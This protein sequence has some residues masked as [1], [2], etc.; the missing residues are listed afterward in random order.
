MLLLLAKLLAVCFWGE[1]TVRESRSRT[2]SDELPVRLGLRELP[3]EEGFSGVEPPVEV[4]LRGFVRGE[5]VDSRMLARERE[6]DNGFVVGRGLRAAEGDLAGGERGVRVREDE[7]AFAG[8]A[9][10]LPLSLSCGAGGSE[11]VAELGA[12]ASPLGLSAGL[13][14]VM[15]EGAVGAASVAGAEGAAWSE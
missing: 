8:E 12:G 1:D 2:R 3:V 6:W 15:I 14:G 10:S 4:G 9:F 5:A 7:R 13:S 11:T